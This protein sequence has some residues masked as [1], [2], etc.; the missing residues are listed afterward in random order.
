MSRRPGRHAPL[1]DYVRLGEESSGRSRR[2]YL[3]IATAYWR[4]LGEPERLD[5]M[6]ER[7]R[8][9]VEAA[10]EGHG[11]AVLRHGGAMPRI[12]I[13]EELS[14]HLRLHNGRYRA[15]VAGRR[16]IIGELILSAE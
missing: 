15:T 2:R 4:E 5:V 9:I 14:Q 10:P 1:G 7:G 13:S 8:V 11:L 3:Y 6:V 12:G 16:L